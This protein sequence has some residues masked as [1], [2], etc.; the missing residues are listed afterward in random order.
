META[1][2]TSIQGILTY[3]LLQ[4]FGPWSLAQT[5]VLV[6][7]IWWPWLIYRV[8]SY[9]QPNSLHPALYF[10]KNRCLEHRLVWL[11]DRLG[12][13]GSPLKKKRKKKLLVCR[14]SPPDCPTLPR[15]R[16]LACVLT[17]PSWNPG[18][19]RGSSRGGLGSLGGFL[20]YYF[21]IP[22]NLIYTCWAWLYR[23]CGIS[24]KKRK[25]NSL[26]G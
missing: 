21:R 19:L 1:S 20:K 12:R 5:P 14:V 26:L 13:H 4:S 3:E 15:V 9:D 25:K 10:K 6:R 7:V 23:A 2:C 24:D 16:A 18:R 11:I 22:G 8:F 17:I